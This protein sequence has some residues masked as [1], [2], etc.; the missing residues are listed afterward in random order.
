[1]LFESHEKSCRC[2]YCRGSYKLHYGLNIPKVWWEGNSWYVV[3]LYPCY[4]LRW[5][6]SWL[7][8]GWFLWFKEHLL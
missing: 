2:S 1:M 7:R 8:S 3:K 5:T 6:N 4:Y